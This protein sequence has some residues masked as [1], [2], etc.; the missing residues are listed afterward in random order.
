M[1]M[2]LIDKIVALAQS[3][4]GIR[5][6]VLEGSITT[7][8]QVDE[9]SD[10][11]VNIYSRSYEKYLT[12][13]YWM[14]RIGEVLLYQKEQFQFYENTIPTRL[15]IFKDRERV[16]FSFWYASLLSDMVRG[17][18]EYESYKNGYQILVDKDR[19]AEKLKQPD[20]TG[21]RISPPDRDKF[22]QTIYDFW[23]EAYCVARYLSRGNLWFAKRIEDSYIKDH[24]YRM[25]LWQHQA[26]NDWKPDPLLH[27][28]GK[29]FEKWASPELIEEVGRCFSLYD[30]KNTWISLY[31]MVKLFGKLARQVSTQQH[32][33]FPERVEGDVLDYLSYLKSRGSEVPF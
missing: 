29:R 24:L 8:F 12:D 14:N 11:D 33:K 32:I 17:E 27:L 26:E 30:L 10:Y 7:E 28:E 16:D 23:F 25:A 4:E 21:F 19:L 15:V 18:K 31:A 20:G 5:A 9:L 2:L 3:D 22:L 1:N 13:D 6:V